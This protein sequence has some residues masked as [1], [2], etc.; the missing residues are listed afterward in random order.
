MLH[1]C[2][3]S[4]RQIV[5][6][7]WDTAKIFA[8]DQTLI[9]KSAADYTRLL[10]VHLQMSFLR[11]EVLISIIAHARECYRD[12]LFIEIASALRAKMHR[13]LA[14]PIQHF[15]PSELLSIFVP[16]S[17]IK[18]PAERKRIKHTP[19]RLCSL[20]QHAFISFATI[21]SL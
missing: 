3:V 18:P 19:P 8:H 2:D 17:A 7:S 14:R 15:T 20:A 12:C 9:C 11:N 16:Q 5:Q 13:K 1:T 6:K 21:Y 10:S 4:L